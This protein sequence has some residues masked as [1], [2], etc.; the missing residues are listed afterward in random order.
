VVSPAFCRI[1]GVA[2]VQKK[3]SG[4]GRRLIGNSKGRGGS[5]P[6]PSAA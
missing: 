3:W 4:G 2:M 6:L 5:A 1:S